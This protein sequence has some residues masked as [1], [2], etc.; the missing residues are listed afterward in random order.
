MNGLGFGR[1]QACV[2]PEQMGVVWM[3]MGFKAAT[4]GCPLFLSLI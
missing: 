1:E 3:G 4:A 2:G